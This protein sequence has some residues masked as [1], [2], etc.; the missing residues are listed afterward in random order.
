MPITRSSAQKSKTLEENYQDLSKDKNQFWAEFGE[1]MLAFLLVVNEA[2]KTTPLWGLTSHERL[3]IQA[4]DNWESPAYVIV[5]AFGKSYIIE[6][7][8]P[9]HRAPWP[10]ATVRGTVNS[11]EAAKKYFL[12][13]MR[14]SEGWKD[15]EELRYLLSEF[16]TS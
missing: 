6:Y 10:D 4:E 15:N 12:I 8:I 14:E 16:G 9:R 2:F 3:L 13:A 1:A 7:L 5:G 11:L